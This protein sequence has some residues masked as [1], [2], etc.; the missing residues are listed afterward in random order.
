M[1]EEHPEVV[2]AMTDLLTSAA[3][4]SNSKKRDAAKISAEWIGVPAEAIEKS[5]IVYTTDPTQ[6]WLKGEA[7]FLS[8]LN[9]MNKFKDQMKNKDLAAAT[10]LLYDFSFVKKSLDRLNPVRLVSE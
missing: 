9:S 7:T 6:N 5:T 3:N 8:M 1:I 2:Q 10:P 4:W